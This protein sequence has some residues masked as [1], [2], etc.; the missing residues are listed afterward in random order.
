[1]SALHQL[2]PS[3]LWQQFAAICDI[4]HPSFH[5]YLIREHLVGFAVQH[6]LDYAVDDAGNVIMRKPATAGMEN[7][8]GV[9]FQSHMDMVPQKNNETEHDFTKDSIKAVIYG[10]WVTAEGTTLGA[11]N[12][13]GMAAALA[14]LASDH[15]E[16][17]PV[18]ALFTTNEEAGMTGA[19]E[20]QP[21]LFN[22]KILLNMDTEEEG[23]LY[24][25]C[26]GGAF[27]KVDGSYQQE[28]SQESG[29]QLTFSTISLSGLKGG[30]SGCDIHLGRGNAI[31]MLVRV[32]RRLEAH[33][34][35]IAS[36]TGGSLANAIPREASAIVAIP[37]DQQ[38]RV[39]ALVDELSQELTNEL[40]IAEPDLHIILTSAQP[41][42][43]LMP[44]QD[45]NQ[46]LTAL[47]ACPNGAMRMSDA[48]EGVVETSSSMGVL[49]IADGKIHVQLMPRSLIDSCVGATRDA[50]TGLFSLIGADIRIEDSYPGW[51]PNAHSRILAIMKDV[52][53]DLYG[54]VPEVK[55]VHAGLECGLLGSKYPEWDMISFGPTICF[56][57]SPDEKVHINSVKKFWDFLLATLK[58]IPEA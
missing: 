3:S 46:W 4:P 26:A 49:T 33:G 24:M 34:V 52:Y 25:G 11:D 35:R 43:Q 23:Q 41:A 51:Q 6:N 56:P 58:A 54:K 30:H 28:K 53:S 57:H 13:I 9:I 16:H 7:K 27:I 8:T 36:M 5:E 29:S 22:G 37:V 55:V 15:I 10:E 45:Q 18:E 1:M 40:K 38:E 31:K 39:A 14:V 21:G 2:Q 17:G 32:L 48:V 20:L 12:G 50:I 19:Q 47:E 44:V 42:E